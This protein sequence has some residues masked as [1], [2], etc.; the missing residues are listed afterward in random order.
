MVSVNARGADVQTLSKY[1]FCTLL[2]LVF[3]STRCIF[4]KHRRGRK[5]GSKY[6]P[7]F[8]S[9]SSSYNTTRLSEASKMLRRLEKGLNTAKM[10][11]QPAEGSSPFQADEHR[12][13]PQQA[14]PYASN[15]PLH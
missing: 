2:C 13:S 14:M 10:K 8:C 12:T 4:E 9:V 5:P 7:F 6:T 15:P 11:S 3:I 1:L